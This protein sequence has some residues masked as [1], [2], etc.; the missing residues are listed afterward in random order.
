MF[1]LTLSLLLALQPI[2]EAEVLATSFQPLVPVSQP[3]LQSA[4]EPAPAKHGASLSY[5]Y[6]EIGATRTNLDVI[7]DEADAYYGKFSWDV[8]HAFYLFGGYENQSVDVG[9]TET[10][11]WSVGFG[12]HTGLAENLDFFSDLAFLFTD[13]STNNFDSDAN[14]TYFRAGLRWMALPFERGG[15]ELNGAGLILDLDNNVYSDSSSIGFEAGARLHFLSAFSVAASYI[16]LEDDDS[17]TVSARY[18]F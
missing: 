8:N 3:I 13:T 16:Q 18:S 14:G 17:G 11:I 9:N 10:D 12:G 4:K 2:G 7:D 1:H 6:I 5:S 15:L